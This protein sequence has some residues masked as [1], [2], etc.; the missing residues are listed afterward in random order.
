MKTIIFPSANKKDFDELADNIKEGI[1]VHFV[2]TYKEIHE[3]AFGEDGK[4]LK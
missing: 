3:L 4:T 1:E 2:D